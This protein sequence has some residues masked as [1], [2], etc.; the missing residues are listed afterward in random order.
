MEVAQAEEDNRINNRMK[1]HLF[2]PE[3]FRGESFS[4]PKAYMEHFERIS[5]MN[6]WLPLEQFNILPLFL[7]EQ[8]LT[9]HKYYTLT[10]VYDDEATDL[11]KWVHLKQHFISSFSKN[12]IGRPSLHKVAE[13][14]QNTSENISNYILDKIRLCIK[15]QPNMQLHD[16]FLICPAVIL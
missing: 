14:K 3:I 1:I 2:S 13:R 8:A 7:T 6:Q 12:R 4:N 5:L 11:D 10:A 9:W 16:K 15:H